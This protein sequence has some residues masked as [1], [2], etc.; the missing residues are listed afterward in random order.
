M[1]SPVKGEGKRKEERR[2]MGGDS[3]GMEELKRMIEMM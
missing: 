1:R 2:G 3:K